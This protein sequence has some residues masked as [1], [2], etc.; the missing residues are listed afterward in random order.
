MKR[1]L[2]LLALVFSFVSVSSQ[3]TYYTAFQTEMYEYSTYTS[4]WNKINQIDDADIPI[5]I[6]KNVI[7]I[8]AQSATSFKMYSSYREVKIK[9]ASKPMGRW[10][11]REIIKDR[12][13]TVDIIIFDDV[14]YVVL[15]IIYT[16]D[17]PA[18]NLRY[19]MRKN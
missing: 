13:C 2:F 18:V 5:A 3:T 4:S 15:S 12:N 7:S 11:A 9:G 6:T 16:D 14:D 17:S 8:S 10:D 1:I 19:Y